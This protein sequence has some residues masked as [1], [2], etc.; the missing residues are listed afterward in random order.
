MRQLKG[1]GA[2]S[3]VVALV[4][5]N[6]ASA[7]LASPAASRPSDVEYSVPAKFWGQWNSNPQ[8]CGTA[9]N[10]SALTLTAHSVEFYESGGP[11]KVVVK[12]GSFEILIVAELSGEG[13]TWLAAH[14][15]VLS[16]DGS[17]V[18]SP[19]QDGS[20]FIRYRCKPG[21]ARARE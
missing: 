13:Q 10:D 20:Q 5:Y 17:Y 21:E 8:Q 15:F 7:P 19:G 9:L 14:T 3:T 11:V 6:L 12:R 2:A 4:A 16:R 1:W 18:N